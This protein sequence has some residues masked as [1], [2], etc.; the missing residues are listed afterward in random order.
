MKLFSLWMLGLGGLNMALAV[1]LGAF[2]AHALRAREATLP[3]E[4][5]L[6]AWETAVQYHLVHA[7]ALMAVGLTAQW[8]D[9]GLL[10]GAGWLL[11]AGIVLF[12]GSLY[13]MTVTGWRWLGPVTPLG[14]MSLII[15]WLVFVVAIIR[16]AS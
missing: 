3:L 14:G 7:L 13:V 9:G 6:A 15:G 1:G 16:Q 8:L 4:R 10:R 11:V 12:S 2:G 5:G